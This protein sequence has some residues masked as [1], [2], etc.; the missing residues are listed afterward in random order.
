M[1]RPTPRPTRPPTRRSA[2]RDNDCAATPMTPACDAATG[3]CVAC[4]PASDRCARGTYCDSAAQSCVPGC[5]PDDDCTVAVTDAGALVRHCD[6]ATRACLECVTNDH[7]AAGSLCVGNTCV[8]GC[9]AER[10]CPT[11]QSCCGGACVDPQSN[12]AHCG[13]CAARCVAPNATPACMNGSCAVGACTGTFS[14]CDDDPANGCETSTLSDVRHCGAGR[15]ACAPRANSAVDC[16]GGRCAYTCTAG[17]ADRDGDAAN[18]CEADTRTSTTSCGA[19]GLACSPANATAACAGGACRVGACNAGFG[20]CD[21]NATNGCETDLRTTVSSCSACGRACPTPRNTVPACVDTLCAVTCAAGY[22]E[23]NGDTADGCEVELA[24][25]VDHCGSC[26]RSCVTANVSTAECAA[27]AC[28]ILSCAAGFAD[29][30]GN[31]ANGCETDLTTS[32]SHCNACGAACAPSNATG[33]CDAGRCAIAACAAGF[34][35]CDMSAAS[36]CETDTRTA[37]A[38]CGAC[39]VACAYANAAASCADSACRLGACV[40]GY[41]DCDARAANGCETDLRTSAAHCGVCGRV[42]A[43]GQSCASGTCAAL[44]SCAA[45]HAAAPSAPSGTYAIDPGGPAG[46]AAPFNAYCDMASDR[47]GW[48]L[49]MMAAS[50]PTGTFGYDAA[51]WTDTAVL[52]PAVTD[53]TMN[54][55]VKSPAFNALPFAAVRMCLGSLTAC[56]N[57]TVTATSARALF[58]GAERLGGRALSDFRTWGYAGTLGCNR[59]GF[60][61][62]DIGGGAARCRYGILLNNESICEGSVD[63]GRGFGCRGYYGEQISAGQGD[64]IVAV[65]HERGWIFAR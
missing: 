52:N 15:T 46:A 18:G 61:V 50:T 24:R 17:F 2:V 16:A 39:G 19:C 45:I 32:T 47:G 57:E 54:V 30:D 41:G 43:V 10:A 12:T 63:G 1:S 56:L 22:G 53:P 51:A 3:C 31:A 13:R 26:G 7:C 58:A 11:G 28:L 64:G 34:A 35:D 59:F 65:S 8:A 48:T 25:A 27:G 21:A 42:C 4:V 49:I 9:T 37:T 29:C 36:G 5:R 20:D 23:C 62:F 55:S 14:N 60:N 40:D 33:C 44:A 6:T 38:S